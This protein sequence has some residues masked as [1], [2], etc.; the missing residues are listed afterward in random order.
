MMFH[1]VTSGRC[2]LEVEG[3][4]NLLL[5]P[6]DLALMPHGEGHRLASELDVPGVDLFDLP[7]EHISERYEVLRQAGGETIITRLADVLVI[8]VIR[9][10][11]ER[12]PVARTGWSANLPC[13]TSLAGGCSLL[14]HG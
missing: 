2:W 11:I 6:G 7:R 1:V 14:C 3:E 12:D 10:W 8:Q 13:S 4:E 9:F 5:Q